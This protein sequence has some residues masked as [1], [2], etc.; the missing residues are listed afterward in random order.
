MNRK[1]WELQKGCELAGSRAGLWAV[2]T[3][4]WEGAGSKRPNEADST[5]FAAALRAF[6]LQLLT[7]NS[8]S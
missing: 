3:Q 8:S 4:S 5:D 2:R 7:S 6:L 1:R